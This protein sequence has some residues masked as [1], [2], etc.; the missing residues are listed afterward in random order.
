MGR[1]LSYLF[2]LPVQER[3]DSFLLYGITSAIKSNDS[4]GVKEMEAFLDEL[5]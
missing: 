2:K 1:R 5:E 3:E 4:K